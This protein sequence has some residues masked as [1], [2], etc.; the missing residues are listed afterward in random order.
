MPEPRQNEDRDEFME[1]CMGDA[2]A[3]S[4]F[5]DSDQRYAFCSSQWEDSDKRVDIKQL[6]IQKKKKMQALATNQR[7]MK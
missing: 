3:V 5:P 1:R 6:E 4:D 2:E 7:I